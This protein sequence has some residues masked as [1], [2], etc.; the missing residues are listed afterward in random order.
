M[1]SPLLGAHK[2][3][4]SSRWTSK[5]SWFAC[6]ARAAGGPGLAWTWLCALAAVTN[7]VLFMVETDEAVMSS[8]GPQLAAAD[9]VVC[10]VLLADWLLRLLT[11][12]ADVRFGRLGPVWGRVAW[13]W[14]RL[15]LVDAAAALPVLAS[16]TVPHP[17]GASAVNDPWAPWLWLGALRVLSLLKLERY[18]RSFATLVRVLHGKRG[19]LWASLVAALAA[20]AVSATGLYLAEL[21]SAKPLRSV[22]EAS[23][24]AFTTLTT[25]RETP[26][27]GAAA[28]RRCR[29]AASAPSRARTK[30]RLPKGS[31]KRSPLPAMCGPSAGWLR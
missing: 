4:R 15:A 19:Q 10:A 16:L 24:L 13:A 28:R 3:S 20:L 11:I 21:R 5:A 1:D 30:R 9:A 23:Y 25:V 18:S 29:R 12:T 14:T 26:P 8:S 31:L 17:A 22:I 27:R 2:R 7:S 6:V